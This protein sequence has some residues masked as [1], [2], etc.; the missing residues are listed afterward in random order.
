MAF[1][2]NKELLSIVEVT[3]QDFI[4]LNSLYHSL[5]KDLVF[6]KQFH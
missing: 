4:L 6:L 5:L 3:I 2:F 1:Y